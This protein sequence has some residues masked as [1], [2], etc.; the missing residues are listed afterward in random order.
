MVIDYKKEKEKKNSNQANISRVK[1][2]T[3]SSDCSETNYGLFISCSSFFFLLR[4]DETLS[5]Q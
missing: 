2:A 5:T 3:V 1:R 4:E